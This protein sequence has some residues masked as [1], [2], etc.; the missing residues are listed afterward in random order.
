MGA[1]PLSSRLEEKLSE[2]IGNVPGARGSNAARTIDERLRTT[3]SQSPGAAQAADSPHLARQLLPT[4]AR[5]T[6][7]LWTSRNNLGTER[8]GAKSRPMC[9]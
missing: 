3:P 4:N 7:V 9:D 5:A 8:M 1:T 6:E 2:Q